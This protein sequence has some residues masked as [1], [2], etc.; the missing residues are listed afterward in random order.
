MKAVQLP[1][2]ILNI[3]ELGGQYLNCVETHKKLCFLSYM[4]FFYTSKDWNDTCHIHVKYATH[5]IPIL[6]V[7]RMFVP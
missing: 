6:A 2:A 5:D 1:T 4:C 7:Y 3:K